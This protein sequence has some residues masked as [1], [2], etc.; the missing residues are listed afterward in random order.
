MNWTRRWFLQAIGLGG[1]ATAMPLSL[2]TAVKT[3][4]V[5][6]ESAT[7]L[8]I[9][10][11]LSMYLRVTPEGEALL[12]DFDPETAP[13]RSSD[14]FVKELL[15]RSPITVPVGFEEKLG[16]ALAD[17][18][19]T[20]EI[21]DELMGVLRAKFRETG[22]GVNLPDD[23]EEDLKINFDFQREIKFPMD[24]TEELSDTEEE[25]QQG[26]PSN[27]VYEICDEFYGK[28]R[29]VADNVSDTSTTP[30]F[31]I[32]IPGSLISCSERE[33]ELGSFAAKL[34]QFGSVKNVDFNGHNRIIMRN[35][36]QCMK[37]ILRD[38][39]QDSQDI[40]CSV[41]R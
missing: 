26:S 25:Q 20:P 33:H 9:A 5:A 21:T 39:M 17:D 15:T 28:F 13:V 18:N 36:S 32:T 29:I 16:A 38:L 35:P 6:Q 1:V 8:M 2:F 24:H 10:E 4:A 41:E 22:I 27:L 34:L 23:A 12:E 3:V 11:V 40:N 31:K 14:V 37:M 19:L 7:A 30:R